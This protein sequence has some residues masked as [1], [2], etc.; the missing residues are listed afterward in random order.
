MKR[1][2]YAIVTL[3]AAA[4]AAASPPA[5]GATPQA[6]SAPQEAPAALALMAP[7]EPQ[8]TALTPE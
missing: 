1:L 6:M 3:A 8:D 4:L 2:H 7:C 5:A